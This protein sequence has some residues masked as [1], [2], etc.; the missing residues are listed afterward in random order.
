M[1]GFHDFSETLSH[2]QIVPS[3]HTVNRNRPSL[4]P[5]IIPFHICQLHRDCSPILHGGGG[6]KEP[7][8]ALLY[9][10]LYT[11]FIF[12]LSVAAMVDFMAQRRGPT[13]PLQYGTCTI[14][15]YCCCLPC[16]HR[17]KWTNGNMPCS[18]HCGEFLIK[19]M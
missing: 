7:S 9:G 15:C 17:S 18:T 5:T 19:T 8:P 11:F 14:S 16:D 3:S 12:S 4:S 10:L 1:R 13:A 2:L 6:S